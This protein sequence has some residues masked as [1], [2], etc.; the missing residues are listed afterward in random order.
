[1]THSKIVLQVFYIGSCCLYTHTKACRIIMKRL[2]LVTIVFILWYTL[3]K[4][5]VPMMV[6]QNENSED[7]DRSV[8]LAS[9]GTPLSLPNSQCYL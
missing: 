4:Q 9:S 3:G 6:T 8:L 5:M 1:M 2:S 7:H